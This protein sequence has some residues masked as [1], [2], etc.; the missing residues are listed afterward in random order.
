MLVQ[1]RLGALVADEVCFSLYIMI[2]SLNFMAQIMVYLRAKPWLVVCV[3]AVVLGGGYLLYRGDGTTPTLYTVTE[4]DFKKEVNVT[5]TVVAARQVDLGFTE[6]GRVAGVY[7]KVGDQVFAGATLAALENGELAAAVAQK[8][9]ALETERARLLS[10][11]EGTRPEE[12]ALDEAAVTKS[13][14]AL[15][16]AVASAYVSA[17]DAVRKKAD[18]FFNNPRTT[19]AS[20]TFSLPNSLLKLKV[21][22]ERVELEAA[23]TRWAAELIA[24][25]FLIES[26]ESSAERAKQYLTQVA[27]FLMDASEALAQGQSVST[28]HQTDI[29]TARA[30]IASAF[31]SLST[32]RGALATAR[33][34]L[35]LSKAG[36][37]PSSIATQQAQVRVAE[38]NLA[39]AKAALAKTIVRAPFTGTV[40]KM[41][42]KVGEVVAAQAGSVSLISNGTFEIETYVAQLNV[43]A[44]MPGNEAVVTLDAYGPSVTFKATV[45]SVDPAETVREGVTTY[46]TRLALSE[47][48]PR[49]RSGMS[50]NVAITTAERPGSIVIPKG[51]VTREG[52]QAFVTLA[53][54][55]SR[56]VMLGEEAALGRVEVLSGL[57]SGD[58]ILLTP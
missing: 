26:P 8:E 38:A 39:S 3:A 12:V 5:G 33:G 58:V 43:S 13:E 56:E 21:E 10:L 40:S 48:D 34:D 32:A 50:A 31:S 16:D 52:E 54:G 22:Q 44:V 27:I 36:S 18:Q 28:T 30:T 9:A 37:T 1:F 2:K 47:V 14:A 11:T 57:T 7:A 35:V 45:L 46:K 17:D 4:G 53:D 6:G 55:T 24:P 49:I 51:A 29:S 23:L 19:L 25:S 20:I 15:R 41:E 42:L